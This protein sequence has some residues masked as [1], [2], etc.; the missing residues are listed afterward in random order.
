MPSLSADKDDNTLDLEQMEDKQG[1][2]VWHKETKI[3]QVSQLANVWA[4]SLKK[5]KLDKTSTYGV[6]GNVGDAAR[7]VYIEHLKKNQIKN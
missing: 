4:W 6:L 3:G 7:L 1:W 5:T 2:W